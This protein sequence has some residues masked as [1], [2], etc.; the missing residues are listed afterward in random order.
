MT[1]GLRCTV[2]S[3]VRPNLRVDLPTLALESRELPPV[4]HRRQSIRQKQAD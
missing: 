2:L 3:R 1:R 4:A